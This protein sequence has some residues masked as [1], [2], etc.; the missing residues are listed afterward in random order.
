MTE[1][2]LETPP[3]HNRDGLGRQVTLQIIGF[4]ALCGSVSLIYP[5][6]RDQGSYAYAGWV[7]LDGGVPYRDVFM[8]K[9]PMTA[10]V[11]SIAMGLFGVNTWAIRVFD[12]GWTALAALLVAKIALELWN[13]RDAALAAGLTLPF[14]YFQID[15]WN[16]AQTD[17]WMVLPSAASV[18]AVLRGGRALDR[19]LRAA[20]AWWLISG[21]LV[22]VAV[23]FK[24]TAGA[25]GLPILI[26]LGWVAQ[27]H[28][29]RA[30]IGAP[31][32]LLGGAF[33][34]GACWLWLVGTGAWA[35]FLDSQLGLVAPYVEKRAYADSFA[36]TLGRLIL[37]RGLRADLIPLV[38]ATPI[39]L[40]AVLAATWHGGRKAWLGLAV[41]L[42][43]SLVAI[44]S[45]ALQGK[46][47][48]YH[49]LP[50]TAPTALI[51]GYG[52]ALLIRRL[53]ARVRGHEARVLVILACIVA[54]VAIT[55]LG[56][57]ASDLALVTV[58]AESIEQYIEHRR[59][60]RFP[61]YDVADIR[62]VAD[63]VQDS[64]TPDQR[65]FVWAFEPTINVRAQR[66][67]VSRFLYNYPFRASEGNR[68][69]EDELMQA[70]R[71]RPPE[72]FV[73]A[74][75]DR[76]PGFTGTYKDSTVLLRE[77]TELHSFLEDRYH[78]AESIGRYALWRLDDR[79]H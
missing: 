45:A 50:L 42:S 4:A 48:D 57:R 44:G 23:L 58:G 5:F 61:T 22:G 19:G 30:W 21:A 32:I 8:L 3:V 28:D 37:L 55:P 24:Y 74:S 69:Y 26:A 59:E 53:L 15:Y 52:L 38:W 11:H 34:L 2:A 10:I 27:T 71:A 72:V 54:L 65:V 68:A 41:V 13:R 29:R 39:A 6:G 70:L 20:I 76:F 77:F 33:V 56:R 63:V 1:F 36:Q 35:A 67:T 60:Y 51:F 43:W 25:I 49:Y 14:L 64:T 17:G 31:A 79:P 66:R 9:P 46:F 62:R 73:V 7:L 40:P 12:V 78:L 18:L 75:K 47:F 16:I